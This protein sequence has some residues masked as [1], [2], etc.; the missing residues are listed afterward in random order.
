MIHGRQREQVE[1][2][3]QALLQAQLLSDLPHQLLF[4]TH[5]FKQ[6]GARFSPSHTGAIRHG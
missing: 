2:Q 3:I 1:A 5:A 6:C 4:S